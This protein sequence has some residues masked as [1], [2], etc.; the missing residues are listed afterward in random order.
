MLFILPLIIIVLSF[1]ILLDKIP[2]DYRYKKEYLDQNSDRIKVLF[3]GSS[4]VYF[5]INPTYISLNSF[6][7]SYYSQSLDYDF[8]I[9][10]KYSNNWS[11]LD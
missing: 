5:G 7:A 11:Q 8:E 6:N 10:K 2:N 1:E 3:L 9:L 4:H